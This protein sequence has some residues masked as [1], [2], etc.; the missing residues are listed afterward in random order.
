M[1]KQTL[2]IVKIDD[3]EIE[4]V[5]KKTRG[6][7][8]KIYKALY[9]LING[10]KVKDTIIVPESIGYKDNAEKER[11]DVNRQNLKRVADH[12]SPVWTRNKSLTGYKFN[13]VIGKKVTKGEAGAADV[14]ARF[15]L[16]TVEAKGA[17]AIDADFKEVV[18]PLAEVDLAAKA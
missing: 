10:A 13:M 11:D 1:T 4:A 2:P 15:I 7:K 5:T 18:A 6:T 16:I 14:E 17:I 12:L 8:E 9:E 3:F